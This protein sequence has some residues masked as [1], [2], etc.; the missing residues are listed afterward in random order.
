MLCV[1][2]LVL[3]W[4]V[5]ELWLGRGVVALEL[6]GFHEAQIARI[7]RVHCSLIRVCYCIMRSCDEFKNLQKIG[8][9]ISNV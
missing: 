5:V 4:Y 3:L 1:L 6:L 2:S 7:T 9:C 8:L